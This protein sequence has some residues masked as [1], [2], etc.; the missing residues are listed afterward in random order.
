MILKEHTLPNVLMKNFCRRAKIPSNFHENDMPESTKKCQLIAPY[1]LH[2]QTLL[3]LF[4]LHLIRIM[5]YSGIDIHLSQI[6]FR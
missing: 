1:Y 2:S 6:Y 4:R 3:Q 5:T